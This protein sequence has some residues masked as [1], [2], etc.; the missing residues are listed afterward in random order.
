MLFFFKNF[1]QFLFEFFLFRVFEVFFPLSNGQLR[2]AQ[3]VKSSQVILLFIFHICT[4]I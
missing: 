4:G 1:T 2:I 3:D